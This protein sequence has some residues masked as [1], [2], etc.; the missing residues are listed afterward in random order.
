M[1]MDQSVIELFLMKRNGN[2]ENISAQPE[3]LYKIWRF[4]LG[5]WVWIVLSVKLPSSSDQ[6]LE[7]AFPEEQQNIIPVQPPLKGP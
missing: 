6:P 5:F 3:T 2:G 1:V 7:T 4:I